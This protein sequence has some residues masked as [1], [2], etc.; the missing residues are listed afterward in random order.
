[1]PGIGSEESLGLPDPEYLGATRGTSPTGSRP[2]VLQGDS[3]RVS[4]FN[5]LPALDAVGLWHGSPSFLLAILVSGQNH[6]A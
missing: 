4:D 2:L 5:L 3:L 1:M 6:C